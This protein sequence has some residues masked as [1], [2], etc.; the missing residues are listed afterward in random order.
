M[1]IAFLNPV[2]YLDIG[3]PQG[4]ALL[5]AIVK[6]HGHEAIVI[7][8][9]FMKT[10]VYIRPN[11]GYSIFKPTE[12]D[13]HDL[14]AGDP[15]VDVAE[16]VQRQLDSFNPDLLGVSVMT[17]NYQYS[18]DLMKQINVQFAPPSGH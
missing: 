15:V 8:T 17:T 14:V 4:I 10:G 2:N 11:A 16:E 1:K 7:D 13:I 3:I 9:A 12:Y 6:E 5:S 18:I